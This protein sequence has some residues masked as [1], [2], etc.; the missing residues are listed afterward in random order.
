MLTCDGMSHWLYRCLRFSPLDGYE[1]SNDSGGDRD[2][3]DV[4]LS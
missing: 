2:G 4:H 1:K 3:A